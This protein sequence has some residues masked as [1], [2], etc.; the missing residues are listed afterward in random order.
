MT[1]FADMSTAERASWQAW[2]REHDWGRAALYEGCGDAPGWALCINLPQG[3]E[4]DEFAGGHCKPAGVHGHRVL[5][6]D[7]ATLRAWAGY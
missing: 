4:G 1:R 2:A 7:P 5:F 6:R 3:A